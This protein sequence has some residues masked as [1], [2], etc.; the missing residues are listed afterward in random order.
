[1]TAEPGPSSAPPHGA[2]TLARPPAWGTVGV[3]AVLV[4]AGFLFAANARLQGGT[5]ARHAQDLPGLVQGELER[6]DALATE[7]EELRSEVDALIDAGTGGDAVGDAA[8][9]A[10]VDLAAGR[11]PVAG[12]GITVRLTDAPANVPQ[13]DW[14]VNDDLVVHQQ[15]L[16]AVIN[17]LW[18]GGAEAMTL[19]GQRVISTSAFR[20]VGNVLVLHG[21][22]YS[23]PYVV[24]AIGDP[25]DMHAA[26]LASPAIR[27][28]LEYVDLIGLGWSVSEEA[29]VRLPAYEGSLELR[30]ATVPD[31][32]SIPLALPGGTV[33]VP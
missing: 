18:A 9:T 26:L 25:E 4:L 30:H 29:E 32:V 6:A 17:A 21:R 24:Q 27:T 13:P 7:V 28:Y 11:L 10:L 23:P 31:G 3:A 14:V 5:D 12:T 33:R 16:Q 20:C 19:Q 8:Q 1:M 15:D 22:H 2:R